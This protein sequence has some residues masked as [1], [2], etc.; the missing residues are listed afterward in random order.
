MFQTLQNHTVKNFIQSNSH[1]HTHSR[2]PLFR[3]ALSSFL[4]SFVF[5]YQEPQ[6]NPCTRSYLTKSKFLFARLFV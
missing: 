1:T 5:H 6:F 3:Q 4:P 2:N